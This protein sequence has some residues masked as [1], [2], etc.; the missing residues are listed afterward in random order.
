MLRRLWDRWQRAWRALETSTPV[1]HI[2]RFIRQ[3]TGREPRSRVEIRVERS[4]HGEWCLHPPALPSGSVVYSFGV[5]WDLRFERA[6]ATQYGAQVNAFDP[7]PGTVDWV[8]EQSLPPGL[9]FH[10]VGVAGYDGIAS[11][12]APE[13][14]DGCHTMVSDRDG[15]GRRVEVPV[16][17]LSTLVRELGHRRVDLLK[18]DVE[19]AEYSA[20]RD[21]V[22]M[23]L[24]VPQVLVEFHHR[25]ERIGPH[26]TREALELMRAAGYR[27][28]HISPPGRE[29]GF[30]KTSEAGA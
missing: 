13:R 21:L 25:F 12:F 10:P 7:T 6:M 14:A 15:T 16:R 23:D 18:L 9:E 17:R 27:I 1:W 29:F 3:R 28:F 4:C 11:F 8:A 22:A 19:G 5:G 20:L 26:A 30:L 24:H 2:K